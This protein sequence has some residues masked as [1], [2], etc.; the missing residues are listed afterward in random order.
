M[1]FLEKFES[2]QLAPLLSGF[3]VGEVPPSVPDD[4]L[5]LESFVNPDNSG[6]KLLGV[7]DFGFDVVNFGGSVAA[8][9]VFFVVHDMLCC[10]V[11]GICKSSWLFLGLCVVD[12]PGVAPGSGPFPSCCDCVA[13]CQ[14]FPS[15]AA[16]LWFPL[17]GC[18]LSAAVAVAAIVLS[19]VFAGA[20]VLGSGSLAK[21]SFLQVLA[22]IGRQEG[23]HA[24]SC[25]VS[26]VLSMSVL[27]RPL[28]PGSVFLPSGM[29]CRY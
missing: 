9:S 23:L 4:G 22:K 7:G 12:I 16:E 29:V 26:R 27:R 3:H 15:S 25:A 10:S 14:S 1:S 19:W 18:S 8:E 2:D 17:L 28:S 5:L 13:S 20:I 11:A 24:A 21:S 6:L